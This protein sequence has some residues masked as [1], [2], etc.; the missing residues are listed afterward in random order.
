MVDISQMSN[1]QLMELAQQQNAVQRNQNPDQPQNSDQTTSSSSSGQDN[2]IT[3]LSN[4][5]LARL[6]QMQNMG[7][8]GKGMVSGGLDTLKGYTDSISNGLNSVP[9]QILQAVNPSLGP[10][11]GIGQTIGK[12]MGNASNYIPQI[13]NQLSSNSPYY[14][15][16]KQAGAN[17]TKY[18]PAAYGLASA[19][20]SMIPEAE[21]QIPR[22]AQAV[23]DKMSPPA[24]PLTNPQ[25]KMTMG[26]LA[27]M[28]SPQW[29]N[30]Q[31][32]RR[33]DQM[34]GWD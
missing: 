27:R 6:S 7:N 1:D 5:D 12:A 23:G 4:E 9:G 19:G 14:A 13:Q 26:L 15:S 32:A 11:T 10:G 8:F 17:I 21:S 28:K 20:A 29:Q 31:A 25:D 30:Q 16:G 33:V 22:A 18:A 24:M 3:K 34:G 2:D